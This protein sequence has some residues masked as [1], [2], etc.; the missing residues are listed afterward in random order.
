M[1]EDNQ[2]DDLDLIAIRA[3]WGPFYRPGSG[4]MPVLTEPEQWAYQSLPSVSWF[5]AGLGLARPS[6]GGFGRSLGQACVPG[7]FP[8]AVVLVL[9]SWWLWCCLSGHRVAVVW[10]FQPPDGCGVVFS[11]TG[12]L[13]CCLSGH[14]WLWCCTS[15][16][17]RSGGS[18]G[19][20]GGP[21]GAA[22]GGPEELAPEMVSARRSGC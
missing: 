20:G 8:S 22:G 4:P 18:G 11:A 5:W 15:L 6:V 21:A 14:R 16:R 12:W 17:A 13:W 10:S 19:S 3:L 2:V 1:R 9:S 7:V